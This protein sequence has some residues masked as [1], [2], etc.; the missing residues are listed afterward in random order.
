MIPK[1]R[2]VASE[3]CKFSII[4]GRSRGKGNRIFGERGDKRKK[5]PC[6]LPNANSFVEIPTY[7]ERKRMM[8][9]CKI[10]FDCSVERSSSGE[11]VGLQN[12]ARTI[13]IMQ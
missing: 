3:S 4:E 2:V 11:K 8:A 6:A 12:R 10:A 13:I 5:A 9:E 1:I 7:P